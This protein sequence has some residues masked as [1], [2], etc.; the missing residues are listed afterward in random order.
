MTK[1]ILAFVLAWSTALGVARAQTPAAA[2]AAEPAAQAVAAATPIT[3]ADLKNVAAPKAED[4]AKGDPAGTI[5]GT[6]S[7]IPVSDAKKGLTLDDVINAVGQ[8]I[9]ASNFIWTLVTGFLVMFMQAGFAVVETGLARAKN[10]NHTMMMNFMVYGVGMLAYWLIGFAIQEGGVGAVANLGGTA[11]LSSEFAINVF[12]KS[13]GL[14]G[15]R[16]IMLGGATYDVGVMV[17]FLFQMVF[18]DT[19]LTIVTGT[20]A[21][22][23]KYS[24]FIISSFLMGAFTYPLFANWAWGGGWLATLGSNYGLG[25]GYSDFAGSGVVHS[26]GGITALAMAILIGPRIGKFNRDGRPNAIPGHDIVIVLL[27]CFIL[28]FGWFGFNPGSTLGAA[29]NGNLR[30]SSVAVNTM[31]AGMTGSFGAM[32]YM[33]LRYGKP[34]ASMTGN[35]LLAGLVAIT[36]PSGF[37]NPMGSCIIGLIAGVLCALSVEFV[38]RVLKLD[39]V[40]GAISVHGTNGLWGVISVGLFADGK[41]NYAGAWNGVPGSV[42]GLFYGDP[43]QLVAQLIGVATLVGFVFSFSFALNMII[44]AV[45]GH[46]VTAKA[47]LE[48]LDIPEMGALGYPEFVLKPE[49]ATLTGPVPVPVGAH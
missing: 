6:V 45:W 5:T 33:W 32:Y 17:M 18:M 31:L 14:F 13:W 11:P 38:E 43:G 35:G 8:N 3:T 12:G 41:S 37:V 49:D 29:T 23:W 25:H 28:A 10:A 36:A 48:G 24:A 46:R 9:I 22:R 7:D 15:Q 26:V 44:E 4:R 2:P 39:D 40:V 30:I 1:Y 21:E 42:T 34:D 20:A 19:A 16:G 27:G 47:E